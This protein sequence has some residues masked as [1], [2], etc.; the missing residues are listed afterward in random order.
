LY[1][2]WHIETLEIE[3]YAE[4]YEQ[5]QLDGFGSAGIH[6]DGNG[7]TIGVRAAEPAARLHDA[8][9]NNAGTAAPSKLG[10]SNHHGSGG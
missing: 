1:F 4:I 7:S 8:I 10:P 9:G 6:N 3:I 5:W 2:N